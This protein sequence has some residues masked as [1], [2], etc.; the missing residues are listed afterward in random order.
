M[1]RD[2]FTHHSQS[3]LQHHQHHSSPKGSSQSSS[4][5]PHRDSGSAQHLHTSSSNSDVETQLKDYVIGEK[6]S[7]L[8]DDPDAAESGNMSFQQAWELQADGSM[9]MYST[10]DDREMSES[11]RARVARYVAT[12]RE[13]LNLSNVTSWLGEER[14]YEESDGFVPHNM[15]CVPIFN[16][17]RDVIGVAQ[18]IN[19]V[20]EQKISFFNFQAFSK[21]RQPKISY[22]K[23]FV[24]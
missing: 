3:M 20:S 5:V 7:V 1:E 12:T 8:P 18:L 21:E 14:E 16:G 6:A 13:V 4:V 19:K 17:Q 22:T 2:F 9:R 15:L 24:G 11:R 23:A 10:S